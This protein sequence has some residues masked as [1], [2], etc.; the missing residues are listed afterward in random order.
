MLSSAFSFS[1]LSAT[2]E[3]KTLRMFFFNEGFN[4]KQNCSEKSICCLSGVNRG[5]GLLKAQSGSQELH[6]LK[7]DLEEVASWLRST[8]PELEVMQR[9]DRAVD[10]EDLR[11][12][13]KELR[14][15]FKVRMQQIGRS[16]QG[17]CLY[18]RRYSDRTSR[19]C[20]LSTSPSCCVL[21]T[22][23]EQL[24]NCRTAWTV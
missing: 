1:R 20:L 21:P 15:R 12:R 8:V 17:L 18:L 7:C 9:S 16:F 5:W 13:A 14:V 3:D 22:S 10:L 23:L 4:E 2:I 24:Q 11:A 6:H 19:R